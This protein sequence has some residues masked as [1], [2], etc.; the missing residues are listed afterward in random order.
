M[1]LSN[2]QYNE[3]MR[4]YDQTRLKNLRLQQERTAR[5]YEELPAL[6]EIDR[7]IHDLNGRIV[8]MRLSGSRADTEQE[9]LKQLRR[10]K[11]QLL[12]EKGYPRDSLEVT[13]DC[14]LCKDTGFID[15]QKCRCF[16]RREI[17]LLYRQSNLKKVLDKEN[18]DTFTLEWYDNKTAEGG[19]S[20]RDQARYV[21]DVCFHMAGSFSDARQNL[22]LTGTAG[23][24]KTF[25]THCIAREV[26]DQCYSVIYLS[27][28]ELF[29]LF[30]RR[31]FHQNFTEEDELMYQHIFDCDL[32]IIDDLGTESV[33]RFTITSLF[34]C[35]NDRGRE[36]LPVVIST[37]LSLKEL[38]DTYSERIASR[39]A[40]EY[41]YLELYGDDI[42]LKIRFSRR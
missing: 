35:I 37:N 40:S 24:G 8:R 38:K 12:Q 2:S 31:S 15:G 23:T 1:A 11:Y 4:D 17:E 28:I 16:K 33:N 6:E 22:L 26:M 25:L 27:A 19:R 5:I 21:R 7:R 34:H 14:R 3:I 42:R 9:S 10:N 18:F 41:R 36:M 32:L 13:Y 39:L 30:S 29:D 20:P